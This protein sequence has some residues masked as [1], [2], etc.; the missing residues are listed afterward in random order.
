MHPS[1]PSSGTQLNELSDLML[2][3][4]FDW[5]VKLWYPKV[6]SEPLLTM[7]AAQEYVYDVQWSPKHPAVFASCDGDGGLDLWNLN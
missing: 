7:E 5:A 1:Q 6:K 4:S 3:S 2:T